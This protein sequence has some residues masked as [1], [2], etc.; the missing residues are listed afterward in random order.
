[1]TDRI[2]PFSATL[3]RSDFACARATQVIRR[4]GAEFTCQSD[5]AH[6]R[7]RQLFEHCKQAAL[8]AFGVEDDLTRM[9]QSVLVKIQFGGLL[10]VQ[11]MTPGQ[12]SAGNRI[13]D[14]DALLAAAI[15][16]FSGLES[17]PYEQLV[18]DITAWK[19]PRRRGR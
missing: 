4:G 17:I 19:L 7:C 16:H 11:R 14:I 15:D 6:T 9:P 18:D 13:D 3:A 2:C 1:M 10:G 5:T 12:T 8:P